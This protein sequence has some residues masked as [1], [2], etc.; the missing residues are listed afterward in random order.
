MQ[1]QE[2]NL[3]SGLDI[4]ETLCVLSVLFG[5]AH[6]D[7]VYILYQQD[8]RCPHHPKELLNEIR[9]LS[10]ALTRAYASRDF[11]K[12]SGLLPGGEDAPGSAAGAALPQGRALMSLTCCF[13]KE[14]PPC[15]LP[16]GCPSSN[17]VL[18][19]RRRWGES[20]D[21]GDLVS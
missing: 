10:A 4:L 9:S 7:Y 13:D 17:G 18:Q 21:R 11:S 20:K 5:H 19:V 14:I 1:S 16:R 3:N 2:R 8:R 6:S 12:P 15:V